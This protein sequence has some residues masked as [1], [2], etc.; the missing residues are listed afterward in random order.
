M[1]KITCP[2]CNKSFDGSEIIAKDLQE[3]KKKEKI[4]FDQENKAN[5][6]KEKIQ[7]NK[8][9]KLELEK[10][11]IRINKGNKEKDKMIKE[12]LEN[13]KDSDEKI[14]QQTTAVENAKND[15]KIQQLK[16]EHEQEKE[17]NKLKTER[18]KE[19]LKKAHERA[20]QGLTTDQGSAQEIILGEYIKEIFQDTND[21]ISAYEKGEP[22]A[23]WLQEVYEKNTSI[24]KILFESKKTKSFASKWINKLQQDMTD[25]KADIGIMFTT[26]IPKEL[27]KKKGYIQ[28][29][30]IFICSYNF[31][32]LKFLALTQRLSLKL[33]SKYNEDNKGDNKMSA[34]EFLTSAVV[35]NKMN[36][37]QTKMFDLGDVVDKQKKL[38]A[39]FEKTYLDMDTYLDDFLD[40]TTVHGLINKKK[41]K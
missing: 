4:R 6:E 5:L 14:R 17:K 34:F 8:E 28:K 1:N 38:T 20:E 27:D 22:G 32:T 25:V 11:K 7:R 31:E 24:G 16:K 2:H 40:M 13:K 26:A 21:Q 3:M 36:S 10:E 19:D 30:N 37:L 15:R 18:M 33:L 39:K 29:G 23:D 35:Q 9:N 41:K 12:L